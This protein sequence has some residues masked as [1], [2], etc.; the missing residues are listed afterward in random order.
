MFIASVVGDRKVSHVCDRDLC[1]KMILV[2]LDL[3][4]DFGE[5]VPLSFTYPGIV[6][7]KEYIITAVNLPK[8]T[9]AHNIPAEYKGFP[10]LVEY[11][12]IKPSNNIYRQFQTLKSEISI[13]DAEINNAI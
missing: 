2:T 1:K 13:G 7:G 5:K 12:T 11:G 4:K 8:G 9:P 3:W 6:D 10:L